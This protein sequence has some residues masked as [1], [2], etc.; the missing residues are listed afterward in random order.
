MSDLIEAGNGLVDAL[1]SGNTGVAEKAVAAWD[2]AVAAQAVEEDVEDAPVFNDGFA[3]AVFEADGNHTPEGTED[4]GDASAADE[5][6][7]S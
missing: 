7:P 6:Q 3:P 1:A 2:A 4:T 5:V